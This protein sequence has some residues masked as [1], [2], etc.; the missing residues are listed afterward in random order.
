MIGNS[1]TNGHLIN[2]RLG[3]FDCSKEWRGNIYEW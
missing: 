1:E 2:M 3:I